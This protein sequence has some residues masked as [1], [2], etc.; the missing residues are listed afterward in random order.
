MIR[1]CIQ[2]ITEN[3]ARLW[4]QDREGL[5]HKLRVCR[6]LNVC[7]QKSFAKEKAKLATTPDRLQ[8][9]FSEMSIFGKFDTF[10]V[11]CTP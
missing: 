3:E 7:Y 5:R 8:F 11:Q 4:E 10:Q 1:A 6:D 9:D 2:Y